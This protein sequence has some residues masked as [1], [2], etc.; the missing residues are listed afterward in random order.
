MHFITITSAFR[1]GLVFGLN[2]RSGLC[3]FV[4]KAVPFLQKSIDYF[5]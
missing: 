2:G 5:V 4:R 1:P 3:F